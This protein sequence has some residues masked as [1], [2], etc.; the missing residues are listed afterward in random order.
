MQWNLKVPIVRLWRVSEHDN[1]DKLLS[2]E[3]L[4]QDK[5]GDRIQ[6]SVRT[7][8]FTKLTEEIQ[9]QGLYFIKNFIVVPNK[10]RI[11]T[12]NH[13]MK[14]LFTYR[15]SIQ[16]TDD[17][18][19]IKTIFKFWPFEDLI[20]QVDVDENKLFG[21]Y[22]VRNSWTASKLW[23]N[24]QLSEVAEFISR[25]EDVRGDK[26][27]RISQMSSQNNSSISDELSS[28]SLEVTI[29]Q[30]I[31][32]M[33][34]GSFCVVANIIHIDLDKRWS[35]L[36]CKDYNKKVEKLGN[37]FTAKHVKCL[38][39]LYKLF[40]RIT[41]D[42]GFISLLLWDQQAMKLIG[43]TTNKLMKELLKNV[44]VVGAPSYPLELDYILDREVTFKV[45]VKKDNIDKQDEV[46]TVLKFSV[47]IDLIKQ[48]R[49]PP[50]EDTCTYPEFN[51]EHLA[52][53]DDELT[54]F[55]AEN[56]M[57]SIS[58]IPVKRSIS[59]SESSLVEID[60][61]PNA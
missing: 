27:E 56:D 45:D 35:Y 28:G 39:I 19:F 34:E 31:G 37:K 29:K 6:A 36:S 4:L 22:F 32:C 43:K 44:G 52:S 60:N 57:V 55:I 18:Q 8:I 10:D 40:L 24:P 9:E 26:S 7:F 49:P 48:Y 21:K 23:I 25:M 12:N 11:K 50:S 33:E 2:L 16:K 30:L 15:T 58:N 51:H 3:M 1:P 59:E 46:Y 13:T 42:T 61:D 53:G 38:K 17:L 47:D 54:D 41:D 20:N 14:L 5:K